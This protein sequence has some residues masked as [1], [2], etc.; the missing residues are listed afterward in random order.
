LDELR[1]AIEQELGERLPND[2]V[3]VS[4]PEEGVDAALRAIHWDTP[5]VTIQGQLCVLPEIKEAYGR[6]ISD[7]EKL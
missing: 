6:A 2:L 1:D 3:N 5:E 7:L 4:T